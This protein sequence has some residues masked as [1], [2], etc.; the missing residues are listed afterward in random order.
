MGQS[1]ERMA[2]KGEHG[3]TRRR[4][5]ELRRH[6]FGEVREIMNSMKTLAYMETRKLARF[7]DAQRAV[8][9][10]TEAMA[11]DFLGFFPETLP[12]VEDSLPVYLL[13]GSERGFCGDFN[14]LLLHHLESHA[15]DR[16][17]EKPLLIAS[18]SKLAMRLEH[19]PRVVALLE[20][21]NVVEEVEKTLDQIVHTLS[22]LQA[23][24]GTLSLSVLY[25]DP[26]K[27]QISVAEVLP[28]FESYRNITPQFSH[29]PLINLPPEEFLV[30][31]IDNHLFATLHKIMFVSLMAENLRR[32]QH[33]E[34]AVQHLDDKSEDLLRVCNALRQ[35]EIIE[36]I[37]VI[38]LSATGL[39]PL[40]HHLKE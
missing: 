28:P 39:D 4:E 11:A 17:I 30:E 6:T 37:E 1:R 10:H 40:K 5:L 38:L 2:G 34:G 13:I 25:H 7:L 16:N 24:H 27:E 15:G 23:Q 26:D 14:D 36:E 12:F 29:P 8:V 33:L 32:V 18:G 3:V 22:G 31:L 21:A 9:K 19:D 35:E 20:G